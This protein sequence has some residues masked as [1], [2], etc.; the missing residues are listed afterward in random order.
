MVKTKYSAL[1]LV[2]MMVLSLIGSVPPTMPALSPTVPVSQTEAVNLTGWLAAGDGQNDE[3]VNDMVALEDGRMVMVG[4]FE[5]NIAFHGDVDGY[6]SNDSSFGQDL[7]V[8][9]VDENGSWVHTL[10]A[11]SSGFDE[12]RN[13]VVMP[14]GTLVVAGLFC[15]LTFGEACNLTLDG[16]A[17]LNKSEDDDPNALFVAGLSANGQWLWARTFSSGEDMT[18]V[19]LEATDSGVHLAVSHRNELLFAGTTSPGTN[20][21]TRIA[22]LGMSTNGA[23]EFMVSIA[24]T[25]SLEEGGVL[26]KDPQG[27]TYFGATYLGRVTFNDEQ[28]HTSQGG[29]DVVIGQYDS[30]GWAWTAAAGGPGDQSIT[31]CAAGQAEGVHIVGDYYQTMNFTGTVLSSAT[32]VDFYE[33]S[34]SSTG[35]WLRAE[36]FGGSAADHAIGIYVTA[37]GESI[38][39]GRTTGAITLG[40]TTLSDLDGLNDGNHHDLFIAQHRSGEWDWAIQGG[41]SGNDLPL[42]LAVGPSG[43]PVT[44][45]IS[46]GDATFNGHAFE[47]RYAYDFGVWMYVTDLDAD[48]VLD[49]EDNCPQV[50]NPS[51]INRDMDA[52]GD[53]CDDDDDNDGRN[54]TEDACPRGD[55]GWNSLIITS[56]HDGDGCQDV[57]EDFDDD[58]DGVFD[59]SDACPR[60][61]VGWISNAENDV[62][63]DGC[64]DT[65][66][67]DDGYIDQRDNCPTSRNP[68]QAD[69]DGDGIGDACDADKD[70][71][72]VVSPDDRCPHD[73]TPW[74]SNPTTDYDGDGCMDADMDTDDDGDGVEDGVD[75]CPF[76]ERNWAA[77]A[78]DLDHDGDGCAD[79]IE[80]NDDDNDLYLD[81]D[82]RC[83]RGLV[84]EAPAGQDRDG[85]GCIDAVE[86]DDDDGD[87]VLDPVD[88]CPNT[89]EGAEVT[90]SGCSQVQ[91]DDDGDGVSNAD[92]YCLDTASNAVVD[93]RGCAQ[94]MAAGG[95]SE[96]EGL[97]LAGWLLLLAAGILGYAFINSQRRPG[98]PMPA[99]TVPSRPE[100]LID[101][102]QEAE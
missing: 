7:F 42:K 94:P 68:T 41:G 91:L 37:L 102:I 52:F 9:W 66:L 81:T 57:T 80:D 56:D 31:D 47:H 8:A 90:S 93:E 58:E 30:T 62:E 95:Q 49:G 54:D 28:E 53:V 36:G 13:V 43:S 83:P 87:N 92:D 14:D 24:S 74:A 23:E 98:P 79:A 86:D 70:G 11:T 71:D 33:A 72:G 100:G 101:P 85:D 26:C 34:I 60:G 89:V 2:S 5:Q 67:D 39:L 10:S 12:L 29:S 17:P 73:L 4:S 61:P 77:Q 65:D 51:Q 69:L 22:I 46:N 63:G 88:A 16:L 96:D 45:F 76:G 55:L 19:D 84:G 78:A 82:D 18:I 27:N 3:R 20:E 21:N 32:W 38:L 64:S 48:G 75:R 35:Q 59:S 40:T 99:S 15:D 97:G 50:S 44:S 1:F 25:Q 6:S